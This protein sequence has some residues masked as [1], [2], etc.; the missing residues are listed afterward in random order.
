MG[1]HFSYKNVF[2]TK[3]CLYFF[4]SHFLFISVMSCAQEPSEKIPF[5][6]LDYTDPSN[7]INYCKISSVNGSKKTYWTC[8][9]TYWIGAEIEKHD[10]NIIISEI[11]KRN[12]K[13]ALKSTISKILTSKEINIL[14]TS[15]K[16]FDWMSDGK[17]ISFQETISEHMDEG[18]ALYS[19]VLDS[20][21]QLMPV[22]TIGVGMPAAIAPLS[23]NGVLVLKR[24]T[25]S[26]WARSEYT[27]EM[28]DKDWFIV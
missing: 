28:P 4:L 11:I 23:D 18:G 3:Y 19:F 5:L 10:R 8:F 26:D 6:T 16:S 21:N 13:S 15:M 22:W 2:K 14:A 27:E 25:G 20:Q 12:N 17:L 24:D 1:V 9:S 7:E